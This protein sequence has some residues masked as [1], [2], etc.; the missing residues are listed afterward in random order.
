MPSPFPG[1]DPYLETPRRWTDVHQRLITYAADAL[2]PCVRPRYH[3][4]M[5]ERVYILYPPRAI[6]P[7]VFLIGRP[8]P[9]VGGR[10]AREPAVTYAVSGVAADMLAEAD[11][12]VLLRLPPV[13]VREPF[14]E[15]IHGD[16]EVVT[17]I[18]VLSP[19]NK[20]PGEGHRQYR[21]KQEQLLNSPVHLVEIDLL[22]TGLPTIAIPPAER[23]FLPPHRYL[24]SVRRG[25][26]PDNFEVY[27]I[28]LQ[29]R[30]PRIRVPLRAPDPDV[31][32][33]LQA[34]F[35]RCYDNG[36]Y[37]DLVDYRQPPP[38]E[39][40]AEETAWIDDLLK[41]AGIRS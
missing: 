12:P 38:V 30:L 16:G 14:V 21:R 9:D 33:D 5:G 3:A 20:E 32:L 22:S 6:A 34:V 2:Q 29:R 25:P 26:D 15:V 23:L 36:G 24:V 17:V 8:Q 41:G 4:R 27:P 13:E 31:V 18:E 37:A 1:M 39:L 28:P 40:S 11:V 10:R 7:D 35:E 19:A